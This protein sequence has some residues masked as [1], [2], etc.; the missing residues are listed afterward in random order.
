VD[1][2]LLDKVREEVLLIRALQNNPAYGSGFGLSQFCFHFPGENRGHIHRCLSLLAKEGLMYE[3]SHT[4]GYVAPYEHSETDKR[5]RI[6]VTRD[7]AIAKLKELGI[8]WE[9][10]LH[11]EVRETNKYAHKTLFKMP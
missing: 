1:P 6:R 8:E 9:H 11:N 2:K 4:E 3:R 5:F 10:L 7:E